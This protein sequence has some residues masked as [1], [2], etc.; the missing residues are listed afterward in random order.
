[1]GSWEGKVALMTGASGGIGHTV[2]LLM[3]KGTQRIVL[4]N[5]PWHIMA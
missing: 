1:M 4:V 3:A 5:V 2:A